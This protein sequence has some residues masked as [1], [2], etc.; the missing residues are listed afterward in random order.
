[1]ARAI[2]SDWRARSAPCLTRRQSFCAGSESESKPA[3]FACAGGRLS[4]P[5]LGTGSP[6]APSTR[7]GTP[8]RFTGSRPA[9]TLTSDARPG[10]SSYPAR[11]AALGRRAPQAQRVSREFRSVVSMARTLV[12][13]GRCRI[14][15]RARVALPPRE[16]ARPLPN[17]ASGGRPAAER[18]RRSAPVQW[19]EGRLLPDAAPP[20]NGG[21]PGLSGRTRIAVHR[22]SSETRPTGHKPCSARIGHRLWRSMSAPL[23]VG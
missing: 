10:A 6:K 21:S 17:A 13:R 8:T 7:T 11:G 9:V 16:E 4:R 19:L 18:C 14:G 1:M 5:C 2:S 20:V 22:S 15:P 12:V 3:M 23:P